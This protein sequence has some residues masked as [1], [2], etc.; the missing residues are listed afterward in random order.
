MKKLT[1]FG[2]SAALVAGATANVSAQQADSTRLHR[3]DA[4]IVTADRVAQPLNASIGAVSVLTRAD[5]QAL[6]VRNLAEAIQHVA[7]ITFVDFEG[8]GR[9]PQLITRGFYGGGEAEYALVLLDGRPINGIENGRVNWDLIPLAAVQSIEVVRGPGSAVWGDAAM[10]AV[11]NV[12]TRTPGINGFNG[13]ISGGENGVLRASGSM[14]GLV[15]SKPAMLFGNFDQAKGYRDHADRTSGTFNAS[16]D[17]VNNAEKALRISTEHDIRDF[18][19]PGPL[20]GEELAASRTQSSPFYRFDRNEE[21]WH[22]VSVEGAI[23]NG[24]DRQWRTSITG[25]LRDLDRTRTLRL[26]PDFADT[27]NR[28]LNTN[29][30]FL[31]SEYHVAGLFGGDL[32]IGTDASL[33]NIESEYYDVAQGPAAVYT[34]ASGDR[35]E[36]SARTAGDRYSAA[37]FGRYS[38]DVTPALQ[39]TAGVRGDWVR[40]EFDGNDGDAPEHFVVNPRAGANFRYA[41]GANHEGR[42]Y[43]SYAGTFKAPTPDQLYDQRFVP[44]PFPPFQISFSN[45]DLEPAKGRNY[46]VGVYHRAAIVPGQWSADVSVSAY[47]MDLENEIDFDI[48]TFGYANIGESRHRGIEAGLNLRGPHTVALFGNYTLQKAQRV[49]GEGDG[50]QLK[51]IP[52]HVIN[53]GASIGGVTGLGASLSATHMR[54]TYLDDANTLELPAFTRLDARVSYGLR[55]VRVFAD[56]YNLTDEEYSTTG[57][58]DAA[59]SGAVFYHPAAGRT[60]HLGVSLTR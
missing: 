57:Y 8:T 52:Q 60:L 43:V 22:R 12:I 49:G 33:A 38:I 7:G 15:G 18:E 24:A 28:Q 48:T 21:R 41:S 29:R 45:A 5:I 58:P 54:D 13:S 44:S 30:V 53:G 19:E 11:I 20:T 16:F 3:L 36:L 23:G 26:A 4:L 17:L 42:L 14:S 59:G 6:P 37:L 32:L 9:D 27:K 35:G 55:S 56:L 39:L 1:R 10:G 50:N 2:L 40:D 31:T 25:E 47:Q 46:E 51:A 34:T